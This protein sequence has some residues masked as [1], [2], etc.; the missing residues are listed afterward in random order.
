[1]NTTTTTTNLK[2]A[3][4]QCLGAVVAFDA[5]TDE[6]LFNVPL[7]S[8]IIIKRTEKELAKRGYYTTQIRDG[9]IWL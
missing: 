6:V 5:E 2:L 7:T 8:T 3:K 9:R 4:L 1:M